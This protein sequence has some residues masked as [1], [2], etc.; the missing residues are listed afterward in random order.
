[1]RYF[2]CK[3]NQYQLEILMNQKDSYWCGYV[4]NHKKA[5]EIYELKDTKITLI[6]MTNYTVKNMIISTIKLIIL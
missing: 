4:Y 5:Y 3:S 2:E 1:M 6:I